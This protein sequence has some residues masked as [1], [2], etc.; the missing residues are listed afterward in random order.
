M[1]YLESGHFKIYKDSSIIISLSGACHSKFG[2][3]KNWSYPSN[4][5]PPLW[6]NINLS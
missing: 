3:S 2:P 1:E 6:T 5:G 4:I